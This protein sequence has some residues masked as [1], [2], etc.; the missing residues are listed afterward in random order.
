MDGT[1][2]EKECGCASPMT[3]IPLKYSQ[4][5]VIIGSI[6][7][8]SSKSPGQAAKNRRPADGFRQHQMQWQESM[9]KFGEP[10]LRFRVAE[11]GGLLIIGYGLVCVDGHPKSMLVRIAEII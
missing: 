9:A 3:G 11:A 1:H 8:R 7:E 6:I 2:R 5:T 10:L 4:K